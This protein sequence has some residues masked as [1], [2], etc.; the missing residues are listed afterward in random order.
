MLSHSFRRALQLYMDS[1][2]VKQFGEELAAAYKEVAIHKW[3][4]EFLCNDCGH[5]DYFE[6]KYPYSRRCAKCKKDHSPTA[7]TIFHGVRF[8]LNVALYIIKRVAATKERTT[9][10]ELTSEISSKF[11]QKLRQK[12]VWAFLMKVYG[13]MIFPPSSITGY[14]T[15]IRFEQ[16]D[17]TI[18]ALKGNRKGHE[19]T[20]CYVTDM[21]DDVIYDEIVQSFNG[22]KFNLNV[23]AASFKHK[24][25]TE[26][27]RRK[28]YVEVTLTSVLGDSAPD[29]M[30][31]DFA[32]NIYNAIAGMSPK[33]YQAY[34]NYY[35]YQVNKYSYDELLAILI[36]RL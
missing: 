25:E 22:G 23:Y 5:Q 3:G 17:K 16:G 20:A 36:P 11:K 24:L 4:R 27:R 30:N 21:N 14:I 19:I 7:D 15:L 18:L 8:P 33:H 31:K 29:Y 26:F 12:T 13:A 28:R 32:L 34:L 2:R 9:S 35:C 1:I 6:G 10:E